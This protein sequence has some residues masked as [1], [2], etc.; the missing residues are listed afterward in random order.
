MYATGALRTLV[1]RAIS[2]RDGPRGPRPR[3]A[4]RPAGTVMGADYENMLTS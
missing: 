3:L 1:G 4:G 2:A